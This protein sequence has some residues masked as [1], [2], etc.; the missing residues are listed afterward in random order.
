MGGDEV[1]IRSVW[2]V[3]ALLTLAGAGI[4]LWHLGEQ[5]LWIDEAAC[6]A[7]ADAIRVHGY[8]RL[9]NGVVAWDGAPM[10]YLVAGTMALWGES[11]A[12]ARLPAALAGIL[13]I[14][15]VY[16]L[17]A[18][19]LGS[20]LGGIL[21]A[22]VVTFLTYEIAWSRQATPYALLQVAIVGG[23]LAAVRFAS[24]P[25]ALSM[26]A[27]FLCSILAVL[28]H[29]AGYLLPV[30]VL[31]L[32]LLEG[33]RRLRS[34]EPGPLARRWTLLGFACGGAFLV[35]VALLPSQGALYDS[36][37]Q[38]IRSPN[39]RYLLPYIRF[40]L[41]TFG[42]LLPL[43]AIGAVGC[44][45]T[46]RTSAIALLIASVGFLLVIAFRS[47]YFAFRYTF[48]LVVP[49]VLFACWL[50]VFLWQHR[51]K[52][53]FGG[54]I[55]AGF[56]IILILCGVALSGDMT[57]VPH[58][59]YKLG[60]AAP[61][62]RWRDAYQLILEREQLLR[63]QTHRTHPVTIVSAFPSLDRFYLKR[64]VLDSWYVPISHTG[65]AGEIQ[66]S[67][68]YG[69]SP[70]VRTVDQLMTLD[71]YLILDDLG[72]RMLA[73]PEIRDLLENQTPNAIVRGPFNVFVWVLGDK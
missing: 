60:A 17:G 52:A 14:P 5:S 70:A 54:D 19:V 46:R 28:S 9:A 63:P 22:L 24:R 59:A 40:L 32:V 21:A 1:R 7:R 69:T 41:A 57:W 66:W 25:R 2:I 42:L 16:G 61:Q 26:G 71:G 4:R 56:G 31:G 67:D 23:F 51:K 62:P 49:M 11:E 8:P 29:R 18:S 12:A 47:R 39:E 44:L 37:S 43:A 27:C 64:E 50:P 15:L 10:A 38:V 34:P 45:V 3:L 48:P 68:P 72:L 53:S 6:V 55:L 58:Q 30:S 65:V 35:W 13:V 73:L 36:L 33:L 20:R